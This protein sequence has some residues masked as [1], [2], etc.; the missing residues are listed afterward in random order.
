MDVPSAKRAKFE[1]PE[2]ESPDGGASFAAALAAMVFGTEDLLYQIFAYLWQNSLYSTIYLRRVSKA[3]DAAYREL[4]VCNGLKAALFRSLA[5]GADSKFL[6]AGQFLTAYQLTFVKEIQLREETM[7]SG[8]WVGEPVVPKEVLDKHKDARLNFGNLVSPPGSGK[9]IV[10]IRYLLQQLVEG[11]EKAAGQ[12][13]LVI[14]PAL[15]IAQWH[16]KFQ[17]FA[18]E[19]L[20]TH[21]IVIETVHQNGTIK[22]LSEGTLPAAVKARARVQAADIVIVSTTLS[23]SMALELQ[24]FR[25]KRAIV[26]EVSKLGKRLANLFA[27]IQS[28]N[29]VVWYFCATDFFNDP[30]KAHFRNALCEYLGRDGFFSDFQRSV[31]PLSIYAPAR[32]L[33]ELVLRHTMY[34]E[35]DSAVADNF[36]LPKVEEREIDLT[37][38]MFPERWATPER[39]RAYYKVLADML[40]E[41]EHTGSHSPLAKMWRAAA[42]TT[43]RRSRST[44]SL[45]FVQDEDSLTGYHTYHK[46]LVG[47]VRWLYE[48]LDKNVQSGEGALVFFE[49]SKLKEGHFQEFLD[50]LQYDAKFDVYVDFKQE[51]AQLSKFLSRERD[52]AKR[53]VMLFVGLR[54]TIGVDFQTI[55]NHVYFVTTNILKKEVFEQVKGRV[56]RAG[57]PKPTVFATAVL[58]D[59]AHWP[60]KTL[61]EFRQELIEWVISKC[62]RCSFSLISEY[63]NDPTVNQLCN[64]LSI[65]LDTECRPH[66]RTNDWPYLYMSAAQFELKLR[67]APESF[68]KPL[69]Q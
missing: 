69:F 49:A 54:Y 39:R 36:G 13:T 22:Q 38:E 3:C 53:V 64:A 57:Q 21:N 61:A 68:W 60:R 9:T 58:V 67:A 5:P 29:G 63:S 33:R 34:L 48:Q 27:R 20:K 45:D 43:T 24:R 55:A 41:W 4:F 26:D 19:A 18:S 35:K 12:K 11:G 52:P 51:S 7:A 40:N 31:R 8:W 23:W 10:W 47:S 30:K 16:K 59:E 56:L 37:A 32:R 14:V 2:K 46:E 42:G 66:N 28:D 6:N 65:D 62:C 1:A 25:W 44:L 50:K 15:L 17:T